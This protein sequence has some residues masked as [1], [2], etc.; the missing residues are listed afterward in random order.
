MGININKYASITSI[1]SRFE[2]TFKRERIDIAKLLIHLSK[3]HSLESTFG[4]NV[5]I[6]TSIRKMLLDEKLIDSRDSVTPNGEKFIKYPFRTEV[7][8]GIYNLY[9]ATVDFGMEKVKFVIKME[10]KLVNEERSQVDYPVNEIYVG[11]EF[12]LGTSEVGVME[13]ADNKSKS[14]IKD[15]LDEKI[16]F[17]V[18]N[19]TYETSFGTFK[20]GDALL[21]IAKK[22][23]ARVIEENVSYFEYDPNKNTILVKNINDFKDEDLLNGV[24]S[25]LVVKDVE[26]LS[27]P[28]E[29]T[30]LEEAKK[31]AY[32]YI[33]SKLEDNNYYTINEMNEV[34]QNEVLSKEII[35]S[36]VKDKM[37]DFSFSMDGF[38]K[39]L[40]SAKYEKLAYRLKVMK[41]L[42]N[43]DA[44]KDVYG[45]SYCRN[46]QGILRILSNNIAPSEVSALYMVMGYAFAKN[47][48]N[49]MVDCINCFRGYYPNIVIVNKSAEGKVNEDQ[50]IKDK[51]NELGVPTVNL[52]VIDTMFH[53]RYL[54]FELKDGTYKIFL[55][56]CEIGSLFNTETNETKGTLIEIP[57]TEVFKNGKNL[58][59][60]IKEGK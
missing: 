3:G 9:L 42:L 37:Q 19:G 15:L 60:V 43:I 27:V 47:R 39:N 56:T 30:S 38:E 55:V 35:S 54:V 28:L 23:A 51:I 11:N 31:Y 14:Y 2:L 33:Y 29:I 34:F 45:F 24:A 52:P 10:R 53:D 25:R 40:S 59:N 36:S 13:K 7:E 8:R 17:D 44:I 5:T 50:F 12:G 21:N 26:M 4:N 6:A 1:E 32:L 20:M 41:S 57:Y 16:I 46:Y 22:Y 48:K 58:I 18:I 49:Q